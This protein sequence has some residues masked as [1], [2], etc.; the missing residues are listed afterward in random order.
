[1]TVR[2]RISGVL[3]ALALLGSAAF[4]VA[5][6]ACPE[7]GAERPCCC[8]GSGP[9]GELGHRCCCRQPEKPAPGGPCREFKANPEASS[10]AAGPSLELP[11]A[12]ILPAAPLAASEDATPGAAFACP[13]TE[14][15]WD[16][17]NFG[18]ILPLRL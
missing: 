13:R 3:G 11:G 4:P 12:G 2:G 18:L 8:S 1:M 14:P 17:G 9:A 16:P 15:G 7:T 10:P 5:V 6:S